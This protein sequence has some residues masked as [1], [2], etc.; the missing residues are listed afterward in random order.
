MTR[1]SLYF[2][3]F[4]SFVDDD[5]SVAVRAATGRSNAKLNWQE[6]SRERTELLR[7][8]L[9]RRVAQLTFKIELQKLEEHQSKVSS[10][11][12]FTRKTI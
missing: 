10:R 4:L 2:S 3:L 9:V 1:A 12:I 7:F 6:K 11:E 8:L 5:N